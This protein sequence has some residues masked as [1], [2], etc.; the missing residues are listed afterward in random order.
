MAKGILTCDGGFGLCEASV[1]VRLTY[2]LLR[3][4]CTWQDQVIVEQG[5]V[6]RSGSD[7]DRARYLM[8]Q[9]IP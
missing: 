2:W 8:T 3:F 7:L 5:G 9:C 6:K 1:C 4:L